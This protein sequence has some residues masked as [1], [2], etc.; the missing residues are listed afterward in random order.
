M[1]PVMID[2]E[3]IYVPTAHRGRLD[4]DKV[5]DLAENIL[6]HGQKEPIHVREGQGRYVLQSG[7]HRLEAMRLLDAGKIAVFIVQARKH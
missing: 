3:K 6:E 5:A 4:E 1:K 2:I 7:L